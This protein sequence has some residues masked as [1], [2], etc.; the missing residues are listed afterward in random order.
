MNLVSIAKQ[1]ARRALDNARGMLRRLVI[2]SANS[3]GFIQASGYDSE[4]FDDVELIQQYGF[5]SVPPGGDAIVIRIGGNRGWVCVATRHRGSAPTGLSG[6][7]VCLYNNADASVKLDVDGS[8]DLT[9]KSGQTVNV[10]GSSDFQLLG[11]TVKDAMNTFAT[12]VSGAATVP[13]IAAAAATLQ[14]TI[15]S[16][17]S[18]KA[19][20][21]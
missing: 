14:A 16:W 21:G 11:T 10:A 17:L 2:T 8:I 13:Q 19:K 5:A 1:E 12:T 15:S 7:E 18:S 9:A 4:Q 20:V 6:G 3:N